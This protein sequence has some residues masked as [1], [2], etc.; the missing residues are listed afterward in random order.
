MRDRVKIKAGIGMREV[1]L[2]G[3]GNNIL[4]LGRNLLDLARGM[5]G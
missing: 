2:A 5:W 1:L 4:P 3:S